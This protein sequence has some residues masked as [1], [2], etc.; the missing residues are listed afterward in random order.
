M[1]SARQ[2]VQDYTEEVAYAA[3]ENENVPDGMVKG[4]AFQR[5]EDRTN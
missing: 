5:I 1:S 4:D 3:A 2:D